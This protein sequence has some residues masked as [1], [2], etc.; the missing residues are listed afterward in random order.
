M[1]KT[2]IARATTTAALALLAALSGSA[3]AATGDERI[4]R[5]LQASR[6]ALGGPAIERR[7]ILR[8]DGTIVQSGLSGTLRQWQE[9]GGRR[10]AESYVTAPLE[11]GDGYDG[12]HFWNR[13]RSGLVWVDGGEAGR[14]QE[15]SGAFIGNH[16]LW[17]PERGGATVAW[18]GTKTERGRAY[19]SLVVTAPGSAVPFD[20]WFDRTTHLPVREVQTTGSV[21]VTSTFADYRSVD[22]IMIPFKSHTDTSDG[23]PVDSR[24]TKVAVNPVDGP[25]QLQKPVSNVHDFSI[26][27]GASATS[28][29]FDL[30]ENHVYLD[31]MLN[32]KGPYRFIFDTGGLNVIDPEIAR[33]IGAT[34]RGS[35]QTSGVGS[36][37]VSSSFADVKSLVV[38]N[39]TLKDQIFTTAPIRKGFG[40]S[41]GSEVDGLIGFEVLSRFITTFDYANH[42]VTLALPGTAPPP[43]TADV[44]PFVINGQQ[45]QFACEIEGVPSQCTLD[46]GARDSISLFGPFLAAHPE[47][48]P[49]A[50][51]GIGVD[52]FGVG[53]AAMGKLGRLRTLRIGTFELPDI[54]ASISTQTQGAFA[55]PFVAGNVG[56]NLLKRFSVY[57]D[58]GKSQMALSPNASYALRDSYERAGVFLLNKNG[59]KLV[60]D[61]RPGTPAEVAG[62][63]KGDVIATIDDKDV[64]DESL[65]DVR[66]AFYGPTG[67]VLRIGLREKG[68]TTKTVTLTLRDFV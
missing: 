52:G 3:S 39:A 44:I 9:I 56:G 11:G 42:V 48:V 18:G 62:I 36:T 47:V 16:A 29:P 46:T 21:V 8:I 7:P 58:Y 28:V 24:V 5:L 38:G 1:I 49:Q 59:T 54:V 26:S 53:G 50:V 31:V 20:L 13:D 45:P 51:T 19:D 67:T 63:V 17:S 10:F 43:A 30:V 57:L 25:E 35:Q 40:V 66:K 33:E 60:Y 23:S 55:Q 34:G 6:A 14:A 32:G 22:G 15:I 2:T 41:A 27:G 65:D 12:T 4:V 37:T 64:S 61:V 68:G